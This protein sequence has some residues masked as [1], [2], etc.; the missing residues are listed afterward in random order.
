[1][2]QNLPTR[3]MRAHPDLAQL[4]RQAKELLSGFAA[5]DPAAAAEVKAR[6][7]QQPP[8]GHSHCTMRNWLLPA[9]TGSRAGRSSRL[10]SM[11]SPLSGWWKRYAPAPVQRVR[12]MLNARPELADM[13]LSY[14]DEH[15]AIHYA[16][17]EPAAGDGP[18][19]HAGRVRTRA[20][21]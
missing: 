12:T 6:L 15:R 20:R 5:G 2:K 10:T 7:P 3:R 11:A 14:G 16:V 8:P 17:I 1:M 18:I 19:A 4:K 13:T 21:A 9:A